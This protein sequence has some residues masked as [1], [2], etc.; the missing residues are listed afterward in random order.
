MSRPL[1]AS[2]YINQLIDDVQKINHDINREKERD[3]SLRGTGTGT[4]GS[5][6]FSDDPNQSTL[7]KDRRGSI[8]NQSK[9]NLKGS[10]RRGSLWSNPDRRSSLWSNSLAGNDGNSRLSNRRDSLVSGKPRRKG[11]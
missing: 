4:A 8:W 7:Y 1:D 5:G 11:R 9:E 10:E 3:G 6:Y 2:S